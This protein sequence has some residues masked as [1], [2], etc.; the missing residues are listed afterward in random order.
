MLKILTRITAAIERVEAVIAV[1]LLGAIVIIMGTQVVMRYV[2][3]NPLTWAQELS[4][5]MMIYMSFFAADMVYRRKAHIGIDFFI[6]L[7]PSR[8][9]KLLNLVVYI[10]V[11]I[12]LAVVFRAS[13]KALRLQ[14]GHDFAGVLPLSKSFWILP[15]TLTFPSM[16]IS[17]LLF[18]LQAAFRR[19]ESTAAQTE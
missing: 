8:M 7:F 16:V 13:L 14:A 9:Q 12:F 6:N 3:H 1:C 11:L 15:V 5:L 17:T 2:F 4:I 18:M 19:E 10:L